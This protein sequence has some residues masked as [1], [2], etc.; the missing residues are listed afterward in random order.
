MLLHLDG[1]AVLDRKDVYA[2]S[3]SPWRSWK[4]EEIAIIFAESRFSFPLSWAEGLHI[5]QGFFGQRGRIDPDGGLVIELQGR[6]RQVVAPDQEIPPV[7][8]DELRMRHP[9]RGVHAD[10][11]A[12]LLQPL[13]RFGV[14]PVQVVGIRVPF[15]NHIYMDPSM[16]R[17]EKAFQNRLG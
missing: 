13:R 1:P 6:L 4:G 9:V 7:D 15:E 10:P 17:R 12:P 8:D 11:N 16:D 5:T 14:V 3:R 2:Q